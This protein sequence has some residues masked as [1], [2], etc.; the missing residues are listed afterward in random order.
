MNMPRTQRQVA[1]DHPVDRRL[2]VLAVEYQKFVSLLLH[3]LS[4]RVQLPFSHRLSTQLQ[5]ETH[6]RLL[7]ALVLGP[8]LER[9][10]LRLWSLGGLLESIKHRVPIPRHHWLLQISQVVHQHPRHFR[11]R[12]FP[13]I[14]LNVL[15]CQVLRHTYT[16]LL[17]RQPTSQMTLHHLGNLKLRILFLS[18]LP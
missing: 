2:L 8:L 15:Q 7:L 14:V 10:E 3:S 13:G 5:V 17:A 18:L 11:L 6:L 4:I 9:L 16:L 1:W 12:F